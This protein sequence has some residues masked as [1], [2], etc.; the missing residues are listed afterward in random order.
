MYNIR[1]VLNVHGWECMMG[2]STKY[3]LIHLGFSTVVNPVLISTWNN[4]LLIFYNG[5][6][7]F[8]ILVTKYPWPFSLLLYYLSLDYDFPIR[9]PLSQTGDKETTMRLNYETDEKWF[10]S[11][12]SFESNPSSKI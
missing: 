4:L 8:H 5:Q 10:V 12:Y 6:A 7:P 2:Y 1:Y 9:N 3:G 11:L